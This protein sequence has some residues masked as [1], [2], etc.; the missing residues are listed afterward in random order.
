[1]DRFDL[2]KGELVKNNKTDI[3]LSSENQCE[4]KITRNQKR[5]NE[6]TSNI[7][8]TDFFYVKPFFLFAFNKQLIFKKNLINELDP[9][10]AILEKEHEELTKVKYIDKI[11]FGKY[12]IDTWYFSPYPD[13]YGKQ[14]KLYI[15]EYCLKYMKQENTF[16]YHLVIMITFNII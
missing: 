5:K 15:C 1:M 4:R 2:V 16:K 8:V 6:I 7:N 3:D 14:S 10:I 9:N 13:D 12:E 11:Q